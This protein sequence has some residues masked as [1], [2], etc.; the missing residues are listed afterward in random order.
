[1]ER[2]RSGKA[3]AAR[4]TEL[5][6]LAEQGPLTVEQEVELAELQLKVAQQKQKQ[7]ERKA[8]YYRSRKAVAARVVELEA[9]KEQG[10]LTVEQEV[11]LAE[12][13]PKV[14]QQ[15]EKQKERNARYYR[16]RKAA[17]ARV[18]VLEEL[19]EQGPL[20]VEQEAELAELQPKVAQQQKEK[21]MLAERSRA[22]RAAVDR[23]AVLEELAEQGPLTVEQE[24]ELAEL[25]PKAQQW[26]KQ[27]EYNA[28]YRR[29]GRAAVDRVAV[30][31]ELA[32][33]GPLTVEQ[34][35]ELAELQPKVAQQKQKQ[36]KGK[37]SIAGREGLLSIVLR[38]WRSWRSRGR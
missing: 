19:A 38:C 4:V 14:A 8:R 6:A 2:S 30:L 17:A 18:A 28:E 37:R 3:V 5:E 27:K 32:E 26:Q 25:Q 33:Q 11:E 13:Q 21:E 10:P 24:V 7:K 16:S 20:T 29:E 9:L 22:R 34:E 36:R 15:K 35:V 12:L 31:E 23:V 1:M